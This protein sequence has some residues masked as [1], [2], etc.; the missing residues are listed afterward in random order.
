M[1]DREKLLARDVN[2]SNHLAGIDSHL[3]VTRDELEEIRQLLIDHASNTALRLVSKILDGE[4]NE[5]AHV[6]RPEERKLCGIPSHNIGPCD[7]PAGHA[8]TMHQNSG[9]G[10]YAEDYAKRHRAAQL[11]KARKRKA[12]R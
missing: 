4:N 8:G 9:D 1:I 10:F 6:N 12:K 11:A 2:A 7:M 3:I 5:R